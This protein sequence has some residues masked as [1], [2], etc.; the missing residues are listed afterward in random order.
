MPRPTVSIVMPVWKSER[1]IAEAVKSVLGQ[2]F[3]AFELLIVDDGSPDGSLDICRAFSD[4]RIRYL[5][6]ENRGL[7]A[8][9]NTG[10]RHAR[11]EFIAFLDSDDIWEPEKL[12]RHVAHLRSSPGVGVSFCYSVFVDE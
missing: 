4:P 9:R 12:E 7:A 5:R 10:L 3:E 11:G 6:Q 8:A 2:T 1:Y